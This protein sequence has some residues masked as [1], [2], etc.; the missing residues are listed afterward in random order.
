MVR[1]LPKIGVDV[2]ITGHRG[3]TPM[4]LA[5]ANGEMEMV[6]MLHDPNDVFQVDN[7]I[8][9]NSGRSRTDV[10]TCTQGERA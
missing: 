9:D 4:H 5:A 8:E 7:N 3:L 2:N 10:P 1:I 6:C